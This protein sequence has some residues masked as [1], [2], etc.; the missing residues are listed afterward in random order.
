MGINSQDSARTIQ[1]HYATCRHLLSLIEEVAGVEGDDA[2]MIAVGGI[3]GAGIDAEHVGDD[4]RGRAIGAAVVQEARAEPDAPQAE[5]VVEGAGGG[6]GA[7]EEDQFV[8]AAVRRAT[9][10]PGRGGL[11][12]AVGVVGDAASGAWA[13]AATSPASV[14]KA[15]GRTVEC[16]VV[17]AKSALTVAWS[18]AGEQVCR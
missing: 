14:N 10:G 6:A 11:T 3:H 5:G 17:S 4:L 13:Q 18:G 1:E 7:G 8:A 15:R 16:I 12:D 9:E 2:A